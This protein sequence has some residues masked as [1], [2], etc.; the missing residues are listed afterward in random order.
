MINKP[1]HYKLKINDN[2]ISVNDIEEAIADKLKGT[3]FDY[4]INTKL[5][6]IIEYAIRSPF[7]NQT[8]DD[9]KKVLQNAIFILRR[10]RKLKKK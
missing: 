7:K 1:N 3:N 2:F 9:I 8:E 4:F 5:S 6:D 10:I